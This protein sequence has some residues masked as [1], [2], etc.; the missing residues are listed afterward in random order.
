MVPTT[1]ENSQYQEESFALHDVIVPA[2]NPPPKLAEPGKLDLVLF[3]IFVFFVV[4]V[5]VCALNNV[6]LF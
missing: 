4:V 2:K 3:G 6:F 5:V 1:R